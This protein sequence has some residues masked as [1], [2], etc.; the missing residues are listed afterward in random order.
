MG[1]SRLYLVEPKQFPCA[2]ASARAAGAT[3]V[4]AAAQVCASLEEAVAECVLVVGTSARRRSIAWPLV[5]AR[6]AA[7]LVRGAAPEDETALVFGREKWGLSNDELELCNYLMQIPSNPG[8][9]SLNLAAAVQI[10]AYEV[11]MAALGNATLAPQALDSPLA[12]AKEMA[13]L[14]RHLEQALLDLRF[15]N[16]AAPRQ[17][18]R[19]LKRLFNRARLEH[20]EANILRGIL[21]KAQECVARAPSR[22]DRD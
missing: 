8:Y 3:D 15:I 22:A 2:E 14:Y 11:R 20:V 19:R 12:S 7:A 16:P 5:D 18:M 4:L 1:L 17:V 9:S 6:E 13:G 10:L 21:A